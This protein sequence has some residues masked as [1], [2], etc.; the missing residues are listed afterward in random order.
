MV[1]GCREA[2]EKPKKMWL[3][4]KVV[5]WCKCFTH[6]CIDTNWK[7]DKIYPSVFFKAKI[8][9]KK[10]FL[11][12]SK[13]LKNFSRLWKHIS[14]RFFLTGSLSFELCNEKKIKSKFWAE[15]YKP[16]IVSKILSRKITY[17]QKNFFLISEIIFSKKL[18][19]VVKFFA[20]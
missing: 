18:S 4:C 17:F 7:N 20:I 3:F 15:P 11:L 12:E 9:K 14:S 5:H 13:S 8:K 10:I 16:G 6:R 2:I 1:F 19:L